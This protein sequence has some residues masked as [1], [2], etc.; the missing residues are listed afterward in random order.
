MD[1]VELQ[2][3]EEDAVNERRREKN[4][5]R[6]SELELFFVKYILSFYYRFV[7]PTVRQ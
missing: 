1:G 5:R 3:E 6:R 7:S 2:E 4:A